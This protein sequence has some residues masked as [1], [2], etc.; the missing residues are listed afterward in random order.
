[1]GVGGGVSEVLDTLHLRYLLDSVADSADALLP[2][3]KCL[4]VCALQRATLGQ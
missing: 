3:Q 4:G 1:M 2:S